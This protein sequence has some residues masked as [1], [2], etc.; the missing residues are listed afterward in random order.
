M[1]KLLR[2]KAGQFQLADSVTLKEIESMRDQDR[3]G[4]LIRPTEQFFAAYPAVYAKEEAD[5][6]LCN[7]N[8]IFGTSVQN[9]EIIRE[10]V[11]M[12]LSDG[13]FVGVFQYQ[14]ETQ[15]YKPWKMLLEE[16]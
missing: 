1:E 14:Q 10:P 6:Y 8:P 12:Y 4:E 11:R 3:L 5:G 2:T 16:R 7:G 13:R 15:L 9:E